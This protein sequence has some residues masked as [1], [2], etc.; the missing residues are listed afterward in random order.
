LPLQESMAM[1]AAHDNAM[2]TRVRERLEREM[3]R[4]RDEI[5]RY[6]APIP[7]CDAQFNYLLESR[8]ALSTALARVQ[9]LIADDSRDVVDVSCETFLDSSGDVDNTVMS[10]IRAIIENETREVEGGQ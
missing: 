5:R 3:N 8:E 6:P 7:A 9:T 1:G 4:V 10:E 2:L